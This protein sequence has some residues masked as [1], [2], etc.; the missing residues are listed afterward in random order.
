MKIFS[1]DSPLMQG[2]GKLADLM[3]LNILTLICCIPIVTVGAAWTALYYMTLKIV[4]DEEVYIARDYFKSFRQNFKQATVIWL[5]QV[6]VTAVLGIDFFLMYIDKTQ[7]G[8]PLVLQV[9]LLLVTVIAATTFLFVYPVLSKFEN[10]LWNTLKN[11]FLM[12]VMQFPKVIVM[13]VLWIIPLVISIMAI[14]AFPL[15]V[16]FGMSIPA[17]LSSM[18]YNKFFKRMEERMIERAREAGE[19]PEDPGQED[20]HIFSDTLDPTLEE[21]RPGSK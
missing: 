4:R 2:L 13:A 15:V 5:I 10:T 3:F 11:A 9:V 18:M 21:K 8:F 12:G 6:L 19:L 16:M 17:F 14:Q 20:E 1:I 7:A